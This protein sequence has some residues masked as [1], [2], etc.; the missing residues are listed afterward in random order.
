MKLIK[1][2]LVAALLVGSSAFAIEN[3]KVSGDARLFYS[4]TKQGNNDLFSKEG[5]F[6]QTALGLGLTTDLTT[7]ISAGAHL[8]ALSTL[9][10]EGQL[11]GDVWEGTNGVDDSFWFDEA[12][13]AATVGNTTGKIG[14]M[15]LDTPLVFSETWSIATN[16]FEAAVL[17]NQDIADTTL[18]GAYV[19]G[20]NGANENGA[21]YVIA[22]MNA[23]GTTNFS[24]FYNGAYALGAINNS[25][26]PL[27]AQAWYYIANANTNL[28]PATTLTGL[29]AYWLQA[30]LAMN[31]VL[32]G[33]QYTNTDYDVNGGTT[34]ISSD[35]VAF[36]L[37]YE[38]KDMFTAKI[39]YSKVGKDYSAGANL[40]GSG[41]SKLYTEG[42]LM[43]VVAAA[44]TTAYNLTVEAPLAGYDF[45]LYATMADT[46][47][48]DTAS[49]E[50]T[51]TAAR[52]FG[53]LDTAVALT[54]FDADSAGSKAGTIQAFL[55]YNF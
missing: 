35:A 30:D 39:S 2:S 16:T 33:I 5:A 45:G 43:F 25:Y 28:A 15:Q 7:G 1:M 24:Q 50:V 32:A 9:G 11:V 55:T 20:S 29:Q 38:M 37:G 23:N 46:S 19:G 41:Q 12:W 49:T 48:A 21:G 31:G 52:S 4:T 8:T 40:S 44:D 47:A 17:I 36:M 54:Y 26:A 42:W 27:T 34:K 13:L 10:L 22:P 53:P 6:A 14:R 51:A 18:V 3:T